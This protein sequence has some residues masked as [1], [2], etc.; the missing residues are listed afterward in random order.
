[1]CTKPVRSF[2]SLWNHTV[3]PFAHMHRVEVIVTTTKTLLPAH[4]GRISLDFFWSLSDALSRDHM[5]G[6]SEHIPCAHSPV[7]AKGREHFV[8]SRPEFDS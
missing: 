3:D 8:R 1:M 5:L 4:M 7:I 2:T 6:S